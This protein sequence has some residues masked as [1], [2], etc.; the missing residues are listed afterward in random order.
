MTVNNTP[1]ISGVLEH[2]RQVGEELTAIVSDLMRRAII[3]DYSKFDSA[4]MD[5]FEAVTPQ[6]R[7]LTYN[8]P[9]YKEKLKELGPALQHHYANN[10]HHPEH[11]PDGVR[12]MNFL[13]II[14]MLC[15]WR[16]AVKRHADGSIRKSL[17]INVERFNLSPEMIDLLLNTARFLWPDENL[18]EKQTNNGGFKIGKYYRHTSGEEI[19]IVGEVFTDLYGRTLLAESNRKP[20]L[21]PVGPSPHHAENWVEITREEWLKNFEKRQ[22]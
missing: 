1:H 13:D 14:E 17:E 8:S 11:Y 10:T 20:D 6:L 5:A 12:G 9:E 7:G 19:R 15:D 21:T 2:K 18:P 22:G 3:H 4:E 16:A